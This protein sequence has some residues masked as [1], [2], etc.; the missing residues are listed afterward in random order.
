VEEGPRGQQA[1]DLANHA[2][3]SPT[4]PLPSPIFPLDPASPSSAGAIGL[5]LRFICAPI[6]TGTSRRRHFL[7]TRKPASSLPWPMPSRTSPN[8]TTAPKPPG[9]PTCSMQPPDTKTPQNGPRPP[10][11]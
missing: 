3:A 5:T 4:S 11:P 8:S 10:K 1:P 6:A 9:S 2:A 7:P